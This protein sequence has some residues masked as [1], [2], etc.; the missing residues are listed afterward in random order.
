M[1]QNTGSAVQQEE[2]KLDNMEKFEV[3]GEILIEKTVKN[4]GR[5]GRIYLPSEWVGT[6]VKI[7]KLVQ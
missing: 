4:N 2:G 1:Y 3:Y 7:V 5:A 6:R